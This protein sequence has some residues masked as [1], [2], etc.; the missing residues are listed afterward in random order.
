MKK[1]GA[2]LSFPVVGIGGSAGGLEAFEE[3]VKNLPVKPGMA[4]VFIMHLAPDHKSM[5]TELLARLAKIPVSEITSGMR[6]EAGHIYVKPPNTN[7]AIKNRKLILSAREYI[8]SQHM[9]IDYFFHSLAHEMGA[10]AIGVILSG[11]ADDGTLGAEAIKAEGGIT[12]AQDEESAKYPGMP[13]SACAAGCVDFVLPPKKIAQELSRIAKHPFAFSV[14]GANAGKLFEKNKDL[15]NIFESL[16]LRYGLDFTQYKPPTILRRISRRMVLLKLEKIHTYAKRLRADKN[17]A[18]KLYGDLLINVTSFFRDKQAF[19]VLEKKVI[20]KI[21]KNKIKGREVRIWVPGCSTGE[22]AYSIA[23]CFVELLKKKRRIVP[24]KIFATDVSEGNIEK[25]RRGIY[26]ANI[27]NNLTPEQLKRFFVKEGNAYKI[28]K[29]LR[30]MCIF[31][32]HNVFNDPPFSNINLISCRNLLIYLQPI[33]QK[34]IFRKFHYGL[35]PGGDSFPGELG[36][37]RR[38]PGT[39]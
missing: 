5:L 31:S 15:E 35:V 36:V 24:I 1:I 17:E 18:N 10:R 21:L 27:K 4:F 30:E 39:V 37:R 29:S 28:S 16:R 19:K 14:R 20:P 26:G 6:L 9:P 12:F 23:I 13:R 2:V 32:K 7:L 11:T 22:E 3:L 25:A 8:G 33:L 38:L 34:S